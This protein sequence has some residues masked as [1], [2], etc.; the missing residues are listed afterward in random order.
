MSLGVHLGRLAATAYA[1]GGCSSVL[2]LVVEEILSSSQ[3]L[4]ST[5]SVLVIG[6]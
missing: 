6:L 3:D 1:F 4:E 5:N 2:A